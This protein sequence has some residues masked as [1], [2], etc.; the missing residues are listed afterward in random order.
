MFRFYI[1]NSLVDSNQSGFKPGNSCINQLLSITLEIYKSWGNDY[2]ISSV[3]W[4]ISDAFDKVWHKGIIYKLKLSG[5][6]GRLL[7]TLRNF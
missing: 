2:E 4:D 6:S 5:I 3:F 1:Q 7:D